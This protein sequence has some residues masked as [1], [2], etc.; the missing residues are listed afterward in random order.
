MG[1]LSVH[2]HSFGS[3]QDQAIWSWHS[4][5]TLTYTCLFSLLPHCYLMNLAGN[6]DGS[7]INK[8]PR[9]CRNTNK[10]AQKQDSGVTTKG[11][12]KSTGTRLGILGNIAF[13]RGHVI[14][15]DSI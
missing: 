9:C 4:S 8:N 1:Y 15:Q 11:W 2:T 10:H 13:G 5:S 14:K 12:G 3:P 6:I 7:N